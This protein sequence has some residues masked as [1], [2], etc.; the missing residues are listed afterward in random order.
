MLT[1]Q[2]SYLQNSDKDTLLK[3][4][5]RLIRSAREKINFSNNWNGDSAADVVGICESSMNDGSVHH[6]RDIYETQV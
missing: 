2:K 5:E 6:D 4:V 3:S 1:I